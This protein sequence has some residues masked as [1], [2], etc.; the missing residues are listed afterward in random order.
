MKAG[1]CQ[2]TIYGSRFQGYQCSRKGVIE[3]D[4]KLWC[5][6]HA[7]SLVKSR[8]DKNMSTYQDK[9]ERKIQLDGTRDTLV[10]TV[11]ESIPSLLPPE[12]LEALKEYKKVRD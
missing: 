4:G 9:W 2:A 11:L 8:R 7:P 3:E 5:R 6:Q 12:V 1:N 10:A